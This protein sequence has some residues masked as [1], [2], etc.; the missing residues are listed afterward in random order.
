MKHDGGALAA[1]LWMGLLLGVCFYAAPI[2]FT[3]EGVG[4]EELLA[5]GKVTFQGFTWVEFGMF[6]LLCLTSLKVLNKK[7]RSLLVILLLMLIV[8]KFMILPVLDK[9]LDQTVAGT[10][11]HKGGLH[12]L[13]AV[14][15]GT[16]VILLFV[17]YL[18]QRQSHHA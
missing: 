5:V 11:T 12:W 18:F 1:A 10:P 14:M 3:A 9:A 13:Y 7:I 4:L 2:K 15:D 6:A 16:K 8:Q 17:M